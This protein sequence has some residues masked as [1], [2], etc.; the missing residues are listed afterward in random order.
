MIIYKATN[1]I[2]GNIY[3]GK[4]VKKLERRIVSHYST[5][6]NRTNV[7]SYFHRAIRKYGEENF[8]W[9]I[10]CETDNENKLNSLEK[11]YIACYS[12]MHKIYNM[13]DGGEGT[14]GYKHDEESIKKISI[15]SKGKNNPMYGKSPFDIWE[16]R[17][18]K[19]KA[20]NMKKEFYKN[21][22]KFEN[23]I[24]INI[25]NLKKYKKI[26]TNKELAYIFKCSISTI[27]KRLKI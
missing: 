12:K 11:F 3:I 14:T 13:T 19:E 23:K 18:G 2:N 26:F 16:K 5:A 8:K 6:K 9:E 25:K 27:K 15:S 4:T 17:F 24:K 7:F 10:L 1:I 21:R 20:N 22:K